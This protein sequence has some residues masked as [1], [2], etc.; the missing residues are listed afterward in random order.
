[1]ARCCWNAI[2]EGFSLNIVLQK[3]LKNNCLLVPSGFG[4]VSL[5]LWWIANARYWETACLGSPVEL[6][7]IV[8]ATSLRS[9]RNCS[10]GIGNLEVVGA[11]AFLWSMSVVGQLWS[12]DGRGSCVLLHSRDFKLCFVLVSALEVLSLSSQSYSLVSPGTDRDALMAFLTCQCLRLPCRI[13]E[14]LCC[15]APNYAKPLI[16]IPQSPC[17]SLLCTAHSVLP[18][19]QAC[20]VQKARIVK[21]ATANLKAQEEREEREI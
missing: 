12:S 5:Q 18:F 2:L 8:I 15:D 20:L 16:L 14:P 7:F 1:M 13:C 11:G 17:A 10:L 21:L 9:I 3:C 4:K 19:P 6:G